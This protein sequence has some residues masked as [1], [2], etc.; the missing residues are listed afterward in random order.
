MTTAP[1]AP[2]VANQAGLR[3][4]A[5][6]V[7]AQQRWPYVSSLLFSLK[8]VEVPAR[9]LET[10]A[11]DTGWRLYYS[12]DF[13][14]AQTPEALATVL[15]HEAMHCLHAH[16][17]RF[18]GLSQPQEHHTLWN[19][20]GDAGINE[21]LDDAG[22]PW[23]TVKPV[24]FSDLRRYGVRSDMTTEGAYF[25][26]LENAP[27]MLV[28]DC[29]SVMGGHGRR[30]E[31]PRSD[32]ASPAMRSDQQ[33]VIRDR[34]A[35]DVLKRSRDR[36]DIPAGLMRWAQDLLEPTISWRE[37]LAG[38]LR[39]D[40]AMVSGRRDYVFTRPSRRQDAL[41][42]TGS[43]VV[44]PAMRQPA[45][46]RV[47]CVVDTSG[48]IADREL[49]D[50][51]AELVGLARASGVSSGVVVIPCDAQA[52]ESQ[53]VRS[54]GDV[55]RLRLYGGGGTDLTVGIAAALELRPRAHILV[56]FTDGYT[57]WPQEKPRQIDSVIVVISD[58]GANRDVPK[59]AHL[60]QLET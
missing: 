17:A 54:R 28:M 60:I 6:R 53:R 57:P 16:A 4:M 38:Q 19:L 26:L 8:L 25:A 14:I 32:L 18:E 34:V 2:P 58:G 55:E 9:E 3:M 45:P 47:A 21:I 12:A 48:S 33:A 15:L 20:A 41:K 37:A 40:L 22:M 50:F 49:R 31:L 24:R 59:W 43:T 42:R 23:P 1:E 11:V 13:V 5:A 27:E 56:V 36:G 39:R 51:T 44:L 30:Y 52:Y 29:G 46:P 10:M 7:I 35:H